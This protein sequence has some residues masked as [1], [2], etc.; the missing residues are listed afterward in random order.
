MA[1]AYER[2]AVTTTGAAGSAAGDG[3]ASALPEGEVL[4]IGIEYAAGLPG[5]TVVTVST[6]VGSAKKQ[7]LSKTGNTN[8]PVTSVV[9]TPLGPDGLASTPNVRAITAGPITVAV[10]GTNA[11]DSAVMVDVLVRGD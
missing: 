1:N 9:E 6:G 8:L 3:E 4:G 5:T 10:T 2:V 7:L 11:V